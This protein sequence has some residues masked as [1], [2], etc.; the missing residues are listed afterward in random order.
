MDPEEKNPE[1]PRGR[2]KRRFFRPF[3]ANRDIPGQSNAYIHGRDG[4]HFVREFILRNQRI[5]LANAAD[6]STDDP[7][8]SSFWPNYISGNYHGVNLNK[9]PR[10][11]GSKRQRVTIRPLNSLQCCKVNNST[12]LPIFCCLSVVSLKCT[13]SN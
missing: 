11:R 5:A 2:G 13:L 8:P 10:L 6:E 7:T 12:D 4:G 9:K 3:S 1:S